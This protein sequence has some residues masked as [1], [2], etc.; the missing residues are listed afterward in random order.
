MRMKAATPM[1]AGVVVAVVVAAGLALGHD[2]LMS[3]G[4][5]RLE[6]LTLDARFR[7]RGPT[8][9]TGDVVIVALDDATLQQAPELAQ[10]RAGMATLIDA[11]HGAGASVIGIDAFFAEG[12][13][14]LDP[15]L[16]KDLAAVVDDG[17]DQTLPDPIKDLLRRVRNETR[18]DEVLATSLK[19]ARP[20]VL[21]IHRSASG[22]EL[23]PGVLRRARYGQ[24]APG[25]GP[26][27][28]TATTLVSSLPSLSLAAGLLG[29]VT[30]EFDGDQVSRRLAATRLHQQ[31]FLVPLAVQMAA[32]H[33]GLSPAQVGYLPG[34][35]IALGGSRVPIEDHALLLNH[36]GPNAF[37]TLSAV[38][39]VSGRLDP[40]TLRATLQGKA[41]LVGYTYASHDVSATPFNHDAP[42]VEIHATAIDNLLAGDVLRRTPAWFDGLAALLCGLAGALLFG[43]LGPRRTAWRVAGLVAVVIG[44][45]ALATLALARGTVWLSLMGPLTSTVAAAA[46]TLLAAYATEGAERRR[47]RSAFA[48]YLAPAII[49]ELM[50]NPAALALGGARRE[51]TLLFSDIRGFT[52]LSESLAPEALT[53]LLNAYLTPMTRAVLAE[54]GFVDKYI[55]DA[56]MAV[57]G[58]PAPTTDHS[59]RALSAALAMHRVLLDL[60]RTL[61]A[62]LDCGVGLNTGEV[63]AGNMGSSERFDY[64]VIGD[65]VN[66]AS[67]LE[68]LTKR[69]G[70][71]CIV[72][73]QT[74]A[75]AGGSFT[76]RELDLVRVK[77][78][79]QPVPIGELLAGPGHSIASYVDIDTFNGAVAAFRAGAFTN[80]RSGFQAFQQRNPQDPVT[81]MY[82]DRLRSLGDVAGDRWDGVFDHAEK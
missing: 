11:I 77:G 66:L 81:A 20:V 8:P 10:R 72:G 1:V 59:V 35:A 65:A 40:A 62:D 50:Q 24:V 52:T 29:L 80:A 5:A 4:L 55:G 16:I 60:R 15:T 46:V 67:R 36:R 43:P 73:P 68:G 53:A 28:P 51:T 48:H 39:V 18:G 45:I 26:P 2:S 22:G 58:A 33:R 64:T 34:E 13:S 27:P 42:G 56:I 6:L 70:V 82:L 63:V 3:D 75:Q 38:D 19:A 12:E 17:M 7:A 61:R 74:R 25:A 69:Y 47:L 76:F 9:A 23:E 32:A 44:A 49:D 78:R 41:V 57:F 30:V 71:F 37:K 54:R 21:A 31:A 14:P 79:E